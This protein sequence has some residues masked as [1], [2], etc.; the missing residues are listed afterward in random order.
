MADAANK[1]GLVADCAVLL[2]VKKNLEGPKD[3]SGKLI[4]SGENCLSNAWNSKVWRLNWSSSLP[5]SEWEGLYISD[6]RVKVISLKGSAS[7]QLKGKIHKRLAELSELR[8]LSIWDNQLRGRL[9]KELGGLSRLEN[10]TF[11]CNDLRDKIP[12]QLGDLSRLETLFLSGNEFRGRIPKRLS[13]LSNLKELGLAGNNL[14]GKIPKWLG[15]LSNLEGLNLHKN[16][17]TGNIP[18]ELGELPRLRSFQMYTN[19]LTG[20]VPKSLRNKMPAGNVQMSMYKDNPDR[21]P[22]TE[23]WDNYKKGEIPYPYRSLPWC[24]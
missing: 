3:N 15:D 9:P 21:T 16:H 12:P 5:M 11:M 23:L 6:N 13:N 14:R 22:Y 24:S 18:S 2:D 1:P 7:H 17:F 19:N 4:N 8:A 20:C 10:L